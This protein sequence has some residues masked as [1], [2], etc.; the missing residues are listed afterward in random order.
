LD[1]KQGG[2]NPLQKKKGTTPP[3]RRSSNRTKDKTSFPPTKPKKRPGGNWRSRG[4][5]IWGNT[6]FPRCGSSNGEMVDPP[7]QPT[8]DENPGRVQKLFLR[9]PD[10]GRKSWGGVKKADSTRRKGPHQALPKKHDYQKQPRVGDVKKDRIK[11]T[12]GVGLVVGSNERQGVK[13]LP[14]DWTGQPQMK[15]TTKTNE[16]EGGKCTQ[17]PK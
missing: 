13:C 16:K 4:R 8:Q 5:S 3:H 15:N 9:V 2:G 14:K 10:K 6:I 7:K 17:Q 11:R 1:S 12:L